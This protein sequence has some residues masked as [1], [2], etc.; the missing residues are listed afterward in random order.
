MKG[1]HD[2]D[3]PGKA[4]M[5]DRDVEDHQP[6]QDKGIGF[7]QNSEKGIP[8]NR[9]QDMLRTITIMLPIPSLNVGPGFALSLFQR[10]DHTH[11]V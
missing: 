3:E 10:K 11:V 6:R 5:K 1:V 2:G 9:L 4:G 8:G 7:C